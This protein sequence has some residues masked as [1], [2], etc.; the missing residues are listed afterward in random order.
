M[1]E[2]GLLWL[3][4]VVLWQIAGQFWKPARRI[5]IPLTVILSVAWNKYV[6]KREE[7][8]DVSMSKTV[9]GAFVAFAALSS[10]Y[11]ENSRLMK[12]LKHDWLVRLVYS[13]L[14]WLPTVLINPHDTLLPYLITLSAMIVAFQITAG[15][16][17]IKLFKWEFDFLFEDLYRA[18]AFWLAVVY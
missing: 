4:I 5:L 10:G 6:A 13:V 8:K 1:I 9:T 12:W 14:L 3:V 18:S 17:R 15:G 7:Y 2:K 11:G 16:I